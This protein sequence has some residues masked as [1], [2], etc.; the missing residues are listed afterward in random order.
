MPAE[1]SYNQTLINRPDSC[2]R[3][4]IEF[5]I[6]LMESITFGSAL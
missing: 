2:A 3:N 6:L 5:D 4:S 1:L